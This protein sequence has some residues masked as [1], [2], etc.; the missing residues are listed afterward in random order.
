MRA[1]SKLGDVNIFA[2]FHSDRIYAYMALSVN[3][4]VRTAA[5]V[6]A[7]FPLALISFRKG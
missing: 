4:F 3:V 6:L 1:H 5:F 2:E 7:L